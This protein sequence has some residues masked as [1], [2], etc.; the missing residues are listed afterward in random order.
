MPNMVFDEVSCDTL[1]RLKGI[2]T[3]HGGRGGD[4]YRNSCDTLSRLKGI[5]TSFSPCPN[6]FITLSL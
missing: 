5:E 2:E 3:F 6:E 1:S 4:P